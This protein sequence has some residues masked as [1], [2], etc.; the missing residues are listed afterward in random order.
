M[1]Q[2]IDPEDAGDD[3]LNFEFVQ[4]A[5]WNDEFLST[6]PGC[7]AQASLVD[8]A[9]GKASLFSDCPK[10]FR[11]NRSSLT[12]DHRFGSFLPVYFG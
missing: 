3:S 6:A 9:Q 10:V 4:P 11:W 2:G 5:G 8:V 12:P 1:C 7:E